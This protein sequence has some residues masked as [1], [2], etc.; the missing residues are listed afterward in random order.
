MQY[1]VRSVGASIA[2]K[3]VKDKELQI[4]QKR[5]VGL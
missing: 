3:Q 5:Y 1:V 2:D 4:D